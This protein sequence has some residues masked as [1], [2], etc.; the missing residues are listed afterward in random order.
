MNDDGTFNL[1]DGVALL[2]A[3][4]VPGAPQPPPPVSGCGVDPTADGLD[5]ES[6]AACP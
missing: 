2:S 6:F 1:A 5:C 4:F 3:L